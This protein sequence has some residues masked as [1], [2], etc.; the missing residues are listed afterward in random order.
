[1]LHEV[2]SDADKY[3]TPD[4]NYQHDNLYWHS[5][6]YRLLY[7]YWSAQRVDDLL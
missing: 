2:V 3:N 4:I 5:K 1:V 6:K 7:I